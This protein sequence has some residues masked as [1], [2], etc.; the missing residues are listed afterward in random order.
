LSEY[1]ESSSFKIWV[2]PSIFKNKYNLCIKWTYYLKG[3]WSKEQE[4]KIDFCYDI[5]FEKNN[6]LFTPEEQEKLYLKFLSK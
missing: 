1:E 4:Y 3:S 2:Y 5:N 6:I